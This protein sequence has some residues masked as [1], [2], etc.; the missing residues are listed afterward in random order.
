MSSQL[1]VQ[2]KQ[3]LLRGVTK[4]VGD[5][6]YENGYWGTRASRD[7]V[8]IELYDDSNNLIEYKDLSIGEAAI[9]TDEDFIKIKPGIN[10]T[11]FGY[12]TGKFKII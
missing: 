1:S 12:T 7:R 11:D 4:K 2:D 6:P 5:K 9:Q 8:L 3:R 10:L